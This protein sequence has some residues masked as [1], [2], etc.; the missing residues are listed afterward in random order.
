MHSLSRS[1][2]TRVLAWRCARRLVVLPALS[3]LAHSYGAPA[4][5]TAHNLAAAATTNELAMGEPSLRCSPGPGI[6]ASEPG[7]ESA[8]RKTESWVSRIDHQIVE[9]RQTLAHVQRQLDEIASAR[10]ELV[11]NVPI[12]GHLPSAAREQG[13]TLAVAFPEPQPLSAPA[14]ALAEEAPRERSAQASSHEAEKESSLPGQGYSDKGLY[15][16]LAAG[17]SESRYGRSLF[18][19]S[20]KIGGYGSF[21]YEANNIALGPQVGDLPRLRRGH[22]GFD[23]RRFVMTLDAAPFKRLRFYTEIEF[24]RLNEIEIE[25]N[26]IPENLGRADRVRRGTRFIQEVEGTSGGAIAM[27]Q[28]WAQFDFSDNF[29]ARFGVILPPLGRFNVLHD[30]DYWDLPRRPLVSRGGPV[31]PTKSAWREVGGGIIFNKPIGNGYLDG[32]FYVVNG[33]QLDFT[34]EQVASLREGRNLLEL[35]PELSFS[36]G[37][38]DGS[39][40]ANAAA[41]RLAIS[42]SLGQEFAFSGYH[43]RYTPDYLV[44]HGQ[45]NAIAFD[46][47]AT[48]GRFEV[49]GEYVYTHF[50][51]FRDVLGDIGL[52]MV[53]AVAKTSSSE[54]ADLES[55][56]EGGFKGPFSNSRRGFWVDFKYRARPKWMQDSFLGSDFEDPQLIPILRWERIWF[57]DFLTGFDFAGGEIT[58][59]ETENLQQERVSFGLAYRPVTSVVFTTA[60]EHN[61]RVSGSQLI[62]PRPVG[63]DPLPDKSFDSLILGATFGF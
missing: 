47:K 25:R 51:R 14:L 53:D 1:E 22:N 40:S 29:G 56:L 48:M 36:S 16:G 28:A 12:D 45:I 61:R 60:W 44:E 37:A 50:G 38:F 11:D 43:G 2:V 52:Q 27:E 32:Q 8:A 31:I 20:V 23:F 34:I 3:L 17:A 19:D 4:D 21:R 30:D 41:W 9:L 54:T 49:E 10:R 33:V 18:S 42:P 58:R 13:E 24:E 55:E 6:A 7:R 15:Q 62:F 26:A 46:G 39:Q 57:D 5:T 59:F 35:E 63:T